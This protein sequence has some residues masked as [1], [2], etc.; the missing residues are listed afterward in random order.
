MS[1]TALISLS[2]ISIS[3]EYLSSLKG[4]LTF[5]AS[6]CSIDA[7]KQSLKIHDEVIKWS[8]KEAALLAECVQTLPEHHAVARLDVQV[9]DRALKGLGVGDDVQCF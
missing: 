6:L 8:Y 2:S 5:G 9:A 4:H 7:A 3:Q 1:T